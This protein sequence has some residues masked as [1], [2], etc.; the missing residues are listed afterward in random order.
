MKLLPRER[1]KLA[2][3]EAGFIA[4]KRLARGL[5]LNYTEAVALIASQDII[6][7]P[8]RSPLKAYHRRWQHYTP[9]KSPPPPLP[10]P[11][12]PSP[13]PLPLAAPSVATSSSNTMDDELTA[14]LA[15]V[16]IKFPSFKGLSSEDADDHVRR[17]LALCRTRGL[18][19]PDAF[20][21]LFP[22]TLNSLADKWYSQF[23]GNHFQE[24]EDLKIAFCSAFRPGDYQ[25][26]AL[27][28]LENM[29]LKSGETFGELMTRTRA[30]VAKLPQ[31]LLMR[32][33]KC[34]KSTEGCIKKCKT[35]LTP[36]FL[37]CSLMAFVLLYFIALGP[38]VFTM[39]LLDVPLQSPQSPRKQASGIFSFG[40]MCIDFNS[41][42]AVLC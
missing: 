21:A 16:N 36:W 41:S 13:E 34:L 29:A 17:F 25:E 24:W 11:R 39:S 6:N 27:D 8:L 10:L 2:L 42:I 33:P 9:P 7:S 32:A 22:S 12:T 1:E 4:Q 20:L 14:I 5:R 37:A 31:P 35:L 23:G 28:E 26:K 38:V 40:R 15:K 19:R 30:L 18:N 3:H